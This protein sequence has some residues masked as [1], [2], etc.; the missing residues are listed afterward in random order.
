MTNFREDVTPPPSAISRGVI[1]KNFLKGEAGSDTREWVKETVAN[2]KGRDVGGFSLVCGNLT[3]GIG[4]PEKKGLAVFS[5]RVK[6]EGDVD[7]ILGEGSGSKSV[8]LSNAAFGKG[9]KK[10]LDGE[11]LMVE[12]LETSQ[13]LKDTEDEL[14][15]RLLGV[16]SIDTLPRLE[17]GLEG[18]LETYINQ[19][20]NSIFVP[21]VGRKDA[22]NLPPDETAA[23]KKDEKAQVV[24]GAEARLGVSGLYGTQ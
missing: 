8:G 6:V 11:R 16:L 7:W 3:A 15:Q 20:R 22:L 24:N 9:W 12:A 1:I 19:F 23:A 21:P 17:T 4:K 14:I 10:V 18:G 2:E 13:K 5:N